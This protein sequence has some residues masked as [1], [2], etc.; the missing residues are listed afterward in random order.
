MPLQ[1][2]TFNALTT[3]ML[4]SIASQ[5]T[6]ITNFSPGSVILAIVQSFAGNSLLMQQ[7][8]TQLAAITRLATST[9][10]DVDSFVGDFFMTRLPAVSATVNLTLTRT[11]SGIQLNVPLSVSNIV[12]TVQNRV[13]FILVADTSQASYDPVH[14]QYFFSPSQT[15]IH[16]TARAV[17]AGSAGNVGSGTITQ[18]VAGFTGVNAV[19]NTLPSSGGADQESDAAVRA[20]FPLYLASL[21]TS[22]LASVEAAV[23]GVQ[24]GVTFKII[25]YM[26]FNGPGFWN[27]TIPAGVSALGYFTVVVDDGSGNAPLSFLRAVYNAVFATHAAGARFEIDR[28]NNVNAN[29]SLTVVPAAGTSLA[30]IQT[31]VTAAIVAYINGLGVGGSLSLAGLANVVQNVPGV[32]SYLNLEINGVASDLVIQDTQLA[33]AGTVTY[34]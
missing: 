32:F 2:Y 1:V 28:P 16:V 14:N 26:A 9:G 30:V 25:E 22:N 21:K 24:T 34:V 3:N 29:I 27:T 5:T 10:L 23:E 13:Q 7:L 11:S 17:V 15:S 6:K 8:I 4:T 33:R 19:N 12:Q 20:R 18:V 31:A